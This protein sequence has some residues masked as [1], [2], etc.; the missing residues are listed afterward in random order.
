MANETFLDVIR[1]EKRG[2][3]A[4][5]LLRPG[6]SATIAARPQTVG[7]QEKDLRGDDAFQAKLNDLT[8]L[9]S[10][11]PKINQ[12]TRD[13]YSK[14]N[15]FL[16]FY[17]ASSGDYSGSSSF[18]SG[19]SSSLDMDMIQD[20][21]EDQR[22][23]GMSS[24]LHE[25]LPYVTNES[26]LR[27]AIG[28]LNM[29]VKEARQAQELWKDYRPDYRQDLDQMEAMKQMSVFGADA[30]VRD[31]FAK[32]PQGLNQVDKQAYY[33]SAA[34]KIPET[35]DRD[36]VIEKLTA[37]LEFSGGKDYTPED[38]WMP[39]KVNLKEI[40]PE[41]RKR[42][43]AAID[44][45]K[46]QGGYWEG[47]DNTT[48]RF[49]PTR[50]QNVNI[51]DNT[52]LRAME[53]LKRYGV[54]PVNVNME[55]SQMFRLTQD[56]RPTGGVIQSNN[57]GA[58]AYAEEYKN[59]DPS[60][61]LGYEQ[62]RS[63]WEDRY[64]AIGKAERD[65][66]TL[67]VQHMNMVEA[68]ANKGKTVAHMAGGP[69]AAKFSVYHLGQ[70]AEEWGELFGEDN[71]LRSVV[72]NIEYIDTGRKD[73][74]GNSIMEVAP[75]SIEGLAKALE[76]QAELEVRKVE[77]AGFAEG[78]SDED[79]RLTKKMTKDWRTQLNLFVSRARNV[80][81]MRKDKEY[82]ARILLGFVEAALRAQV[83]RMYIDK[84]RM[85][86][87]FYNEMKGRINLT[88][89]LQTEA[90]AG[91]V[92]QN[93]ANEAKDRAESKR[94]LI[95]RYEDPDYEL[96]PGGMPVGGPVTQDLPG[97]SSQ[98]ITEQQ[99]RLNQIR[100]EAGLPPQ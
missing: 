6:F 38:F 85:L 39:H 37:A 23:R 21:L 28:G 59:S 90:G 46:L 17:G 47:E 81:K 32:M 75:E 89:W 35:A 80:D 64:W 53:T 82:S 41:G 61:R 56:G 15:K 63:D 48:L 92:L 78:T 66:V 67:Q 29:T 96:T 2:Q 30:Y 74:D 70:L 8:P 42:V 9:T 91:S 99:R 79:K 95:T 5:D 31:I 100:A 14:Y 94:H 24:Q 62:Q 93:V 83:A 4:Q 97:L 72:G 52:N 16:Q 27:A 98:G 45:L 22:E 43:R 18:Q 25:I 60:G 1:K 73:K 68:L 19:L 10:V 40:G 58:M 13:V 50:I 36:A 65:R 76:Q 11:Y 49:N 55:G 44:H 33:A 71:P 69:G 12:E 84:D 57:P 88:G 34:N 7:A 54:V 20:L 26:Q 3:A 87:S 51:K 77:T 86:A